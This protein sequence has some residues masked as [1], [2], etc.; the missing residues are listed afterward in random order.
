MKGSEVLNRVYRDVLTSD[1]DKVADGVRIISAAAEVQPDALDGLRRLLREALNRD[2]P[3]G[4][5]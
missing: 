1:Y 5:R 4:S 3:R 2:D